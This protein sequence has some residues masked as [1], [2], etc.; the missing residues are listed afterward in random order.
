MFICDLFTEKIHTREWRDAAEV[1]L[2]ITHSSAGVER[3][4]FSCYH[5]NF[6]LELKW[7]LLEGHCTFQRARKKQIHEWA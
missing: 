1:C 5:E 7:I 4:F 2:L 6:H 3:L